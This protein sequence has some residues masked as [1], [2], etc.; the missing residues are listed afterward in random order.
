MKRLYLLLLFG[1]ASIA[2]ADEGMWTFDNF[3]KA[4][5]KQKYGVDIGDS[6]LDR[7]QRSITRLEGGCTGSFASPD[8]LMLTNHHCAMTCV[9]EL[10]TA[11]DNLVENGF[12]AGGRAGER[13]CP[14]NLVSVLVGIEDITAQVNTA[15]AGLP[16]AKA[17]EVRKQTLSRLESAC[18]AART[19]AARSPASP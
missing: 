6:W 7:L 1:I 17:N 15:T 11:S 13:K 19:R 5:V 18:T 9:S 12:N 3:P 8:G 4:T 14:G 2:V 10:S 16:D